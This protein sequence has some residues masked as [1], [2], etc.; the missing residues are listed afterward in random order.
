MSVG[1]DGREDRRVGRRRTEAWRGGWKVGEE[2]G[3]KD[4]KGM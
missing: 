2:D 4:K 1:V 3:R